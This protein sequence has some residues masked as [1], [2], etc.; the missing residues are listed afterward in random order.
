M[1]ENTLSIAKPPSRF[2]AS[3]IAC[4]EVSVN[5]LQKA[6]QGARFVRTVMETLPSSVSEERSRP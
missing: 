4:G 2:T 1:D 3:S 5:V 6:K